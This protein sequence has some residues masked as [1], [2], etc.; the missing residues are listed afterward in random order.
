MGI[1]TFNVKFLKV[2]VTT[3]NDDIYDF[4]DNVIPGMRS[5]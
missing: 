1:G 2:I 4:L 3:Q 5:I